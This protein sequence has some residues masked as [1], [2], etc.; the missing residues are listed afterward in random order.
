M[1]LCVFLINSCTACKEDVEAEP[2]T[3][4]PLLWVSLHGWL[5]SALSTLAQSTPLRQA[6]PKHLEGPEAGA[7][8]SAAGGT[9]HADAQGGHNALPRISHGE[10][11]PLFENK[12]GLPS[13]KAYR[14]DWRINTSD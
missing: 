2:S 11:Q 10:K 13:Q 3:V 4:T 14:A 8:L 6:H 9:H 12:A 7:C 5:P 1:S